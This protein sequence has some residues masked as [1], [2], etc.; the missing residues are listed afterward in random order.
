[1][2]LP[3]GW[4]MIKADYKQVQMR[5]LANLSQDPGLVAAFR[6]GRDVHRLT[7]EMCDIQGSSEKEK[8]DKAK[9]EN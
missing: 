8:R 3:S 4:T 6:D 9:A 7:V 2:G 5:I 1:M